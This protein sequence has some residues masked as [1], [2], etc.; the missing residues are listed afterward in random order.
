MEFV[1]KG[2][3]RAL[4]DI[5]VTPVTKEVSAERVA[6]R[7]DDASQDFAT[8]STDGRA[9]TACTPWTGIK[10][11]ARAHVQT[12]AVDMGYVRTACVSA[13][14]G[15]PVEDVTRS[16]VREPTYASSRA[17]DGA[18]VWMVSVHVFTDHRAHLVRSLPR[19]HARMIVRAR[20]AEYV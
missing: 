1:T 12:H 7:T 11:N 3:V 4:L 10:I 17:A 2:I 14:L 5:V 9:E 20:N 16:N 18:C 15:G 19:N 8:V 6:A 13:T